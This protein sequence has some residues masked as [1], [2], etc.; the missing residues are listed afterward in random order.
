MK[1]APVESDMAP[2]S[3]ENRLHRVAFIVCDVD[4]LDS[5]FRFSIFDF[6]FVVWESRGGDP[7]RVVSPAL[8]SE[9]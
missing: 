5:D 9:A 7:L 3:I 4:G 1:Q 6:R 8:F 2:D